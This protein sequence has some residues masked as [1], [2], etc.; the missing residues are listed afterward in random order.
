[1]NRQLHDDGAVIGY[2]PNLQYNKDAQSTAEVKQSSADTKSIQYSDTINSIA[3]NLPSSSIANINRVLQNIQ[4][5][6]DKL[7]SKFQN[8]NWG[9][10]SEISSLMTALKNNNIEYTNNFVEFHSNTVTGSII[11]ELIEIIYGTQQRLEIL[12]STLKEL[13]YGD[14]NITLEKAKE[15]DEAFL[16][17]IRSHEASGEIEHVNYLA[18]SYDALI[19]RSANMYAMTAYQ[20]II[21]VADI[22]L[23]PADNAVADKSKESFVE[24]MFEDTNFEINYR[25][26][27]YNTQ[28]G[29]EIMQ[30]TLYNYYIKRQEL[31][32]LYDLFNVNPES[33]FIGNKIQ[34]YTNKLDDALMDVNKSFAGNQYFLSEMVKLE[35]EKHFL[36]NLYDSFNYNSET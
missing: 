6:I 23:I 17:A 35:S 27:N 2:K 9:Q 5:L 28:Q 32:E 18:L 15:V 4:S 13:Y 10:Y 14:S 20:Q 16:K 29:I 31:L 22:V 19:N 34:L 30:K 11:P 36:K 26:D 7:A 8:G 1:M 33:G 24:K 21:D 12:Q 3:N 25:K